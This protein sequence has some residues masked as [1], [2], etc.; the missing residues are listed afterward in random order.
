MTTRRCVGI[1]LACAAQG[2]GASGCICPDACYESLADSPAVSLPDDEARHCYAAEWWYYTGL[3]TASDGREYGFEAVIF[4][5]APDI[6]VATPEG[7]PIALPVN[8]YVAH[9]AITDVTDQTFTYDQVRTV[10]PQPVVGEGFHL[11]TSL[12][13]LLGGE[14]RDHISGVMPDRSYE[15]DLVLGADGEPVLHGQDG[16]VRYGTGGGSFYYSR[17]WMTASGYLHDGDEVLPVSG[18]VWFDRQWG[19]DVRNPFLKWVWFSLRL[20]D[21]TAIMLY[22]F[23]DGDTTLD[24]GTLS[25]VGGTALILKPDDFT[26]I[27]DEF[28]TSPDSGARYPVRWRVEIPAA[29]LRL[30]V[31]RALDNQELDTWPTTLNVY[32]EGLCWITGTREGE[33]IS[34]HAYV[35]MTNLDTP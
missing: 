13:T 27:N 14:G 10:L 20:D 1:V 4:H 7:L 25:T 11:T 34:G 18:K 15:L 5:T 19:R 9:F 28:W 3:L 21:G 2:W 12:L 17:P 23:L 35:E 29:G 30:D 24:Q 6:F 16:Y 26:I 31:N 22:R 33:P 8:T 32:W